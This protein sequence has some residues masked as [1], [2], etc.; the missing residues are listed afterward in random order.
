MNIIIIGGG[1]SGLTCAI[2]LKRFG[3]SV[4]V[5]NGYSLGSLSE[6]NKVENFPGFPNG[7]NGY[8]LLNNIQQQAIN[9]GVDIKDNLVIK[10]NDNK[11]ITLDDDTIISY[12]KLVLATGM[13]HK[14]MNFTN[15]ENYMN[16]HYCA[17]CDGPLY[18]DK[19]IAIIGGGDTAV[20]EAI[21][22][23]SICKQVF[24]IV[25]KD[26]CR[27]SYHLIKHM[28]SISNIEPIYNAEIQ[29]IDSIS[30]INDKQHNIITDI[31]VF[32][33]NQKNTFRKLNINGLFISIGF[34]PNISLITDKENIKDLYMCGDCIENKYRQAIIAAGEGAK[35]AIDIYNDIMLN[36]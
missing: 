20:S 10:I 33:N 30:N 3:Y 15:E 12:D 26:K 27:A 5:Y 34:T 17:T 24:L 11:T 6:T 7:I 31:F 25:R 13:T 9:I 16:I 29:Q 4:T 32:F 36:D 22:L 35:T 2:Y 21:Y 23:S 18:K 14:K 8:D 28:N 1:V 19:T